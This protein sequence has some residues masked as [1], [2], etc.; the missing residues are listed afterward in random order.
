MKQ[1][2]TH[3][4]LQFKHGNKYLPYQWLTFSSHVACKMLYVCIL[5]HRE[6]FSDSVNSRLFYFIQICDSNHF[7]WIYLHWGHY[8]S[9]LTMFRQQWILLCMTMLRRLAPRPNAISHNISLCLPHNS[10]LFQNVIA[11]SVL[12]TATKLYETRARIA[13]SCF[14]SNKEIKQRHNLL[15]R[16]TDYKLHNF[17]QFNVDNCAILEL[18]FCLILTC[19]QKRKLQSQH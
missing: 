1:V 17:C 18:Y 12:H 13:Q 3:L 19:I 5:F 15:G 10:D 8:I 2:T 6:H 4:C 9:T 16:F 7:V 11:S 14:W